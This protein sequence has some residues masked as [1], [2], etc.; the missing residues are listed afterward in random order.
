MLLPAEAGG[1]S[2]PF[3]ARALCGVC[4]REAENFLRR[5]I[6]PSQRAR[7]GDIVL[8]VLS[9]PLLP[10]RRLHLVGLS[11]KHGDGNRET[12]KHC[13]WW[14]AACGGQYNWRDP[15]RMPMRRGCF[16]FTPR[17]TADQFAS[18]WRPIGGTRLFRGF[19]RAEQAEQNEWAEEVHRGGQASG[20]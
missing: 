13:F 3:S 5:L 12:K 8:R 16:L 10:D 17:Q 14:C 4:W 11:Q 9:V 6:A 15:N 19:A 18:W 20:G 2:A 7:R 1:R